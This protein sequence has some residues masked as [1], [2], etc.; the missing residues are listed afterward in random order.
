MYTVTNV[1]HLVADYI[2]AAP[3]WCMNI[4]MSIREEIYV[5]NVSNF[6]PRNGD[7]EI[8]QKFKNTISHAHWRFGFAAIPFL[9]YRNH[10]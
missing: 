3:A 1:F 8:V 4:E 10:S 9:V 7:R 6:L 2:G 5:G